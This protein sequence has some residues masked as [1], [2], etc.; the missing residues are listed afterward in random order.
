MATRYAV[1]TVFKIIDQFTNPLGSINKEG[2]ALGNLIKNDLHSAEKTL[3]AIPGK[4]V[5]MGKSAL[6]WGVGGVAAG[7]A[8]ATKQFIQFDDA[9]T[10]AG[11]KFKDLDVTSADYQDNLAALGA[12][13]RRVAAMTPFSATDTA[14]ALDKM[15]MA[16][17]ESGQAMKLLEGT[18]DLARAT[19]IDLT[20]AVDMATDAMGAFNLMKDEFGNPL[21][22]NA[23]AGNLQHLSDVVAKTTNMANTDMNMWFESVKM[24]APVF[25]SLGGNIEDFSA[26]VGVLANAGIKGGE[27]GT[28]LRNMMLNLSAPT[29]TAQEAMQKLGISAYDSAGNMLPILD[30][31]K[32]FE[33]AFGDTAGLEAY[34][35]ALAEAGGNVDA[36][37]IADFVSVDQGTKIQSLEAIFGKRTV[38]DFL[39]LLNEGTEGIEKFSAAL[40]N[41]EGAAKNMANA[42]QQSLSG[43][44]KSLASAATELG[45]KFVEAFKSRGSDGIQKLITTIQS[46]DPTTLINGLMVLVDLV[47]GFVTTL[48]NLRGIIIPLIA[49]FATYKAL[50]MAVAIGMKAVEIATTAYQIVTGFATGIQLAHNAALWGTAAAIEGNTVAS[51]AGRIGMAAYAAVSKIA[52]AAQW[53]LNASLFGCPVVWLVAGIVAL[54]AIIIGVIAVIKNWGA[55]SEW[56]SGLWQNI[57]EF[58]SGFFTSLAEWFSGAWQTTVEFFSGIWE[59]V[60]GFFATAVNAIAGVVE[61]AKTAIQ[62]L[63]DFITGIFTGILNGWNMLVSAFQAGGFVG[64]LR[65]IGGAIL[66]FILAPVEKVMAGLEWIPGIG[67]KISEWKNSLASFRTELINGEPASTPPMTQRDAQSIST[68]RYFNQTENNSNV[69]I[70]LERGLTAKVSG[71]APNVR[72]QQ[73]HSGGF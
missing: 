10:A 30:I 31:L 63:F 69:T 34:Q 72:V 61:S 50:I 66:S 41:S 13:A 4:I 48:I 19:S 35:K 11:A 22:E 67:G 51:V 29:K 1:E 68:E 59:T 20:S 36:V 8:V 2:K 55:I 27:A 28:A 5:D 12:E 47:T 43:Q 17:L 14:G 54:I 60:Q 37:N 21:D 42:M 9:I 56:F 45:F 26:M 53:I 25:S 71:A 18:T 3:N 15:A 16:G 32:Q 7:L 65:Q 24:G 64:V 44:L 73:Y 39:I 23:L 46:F 6:K 33:T 52:A 58:F 57:A 40:L 62:P 70:G 49:A 38:G